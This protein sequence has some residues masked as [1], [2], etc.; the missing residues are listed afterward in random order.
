MRAFSRDSFRFQTYVCF[1]PIT[2]ALKTN[3]EEVNWEDW[4]TDNVKHET[5]L[6]LILGHKLM[7]AKDWKKRLQ[8][9][10]FELYGVKA[11]KYKK[12]KQSICQLCVEVF[13]KRGIL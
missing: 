5:I 3:T 12:P 9:H 4:L 6:S 8:Y 2:D 10:G 1:V 13:Q 11:I 7:G